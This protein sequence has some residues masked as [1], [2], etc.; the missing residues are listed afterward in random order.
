M[1]EHVIFDLGKVLVQ[2]DRQI[3]YRRLHPF[4]PDENK[5][6]L[7]HRSHELERMLHGPAVELESGRMPFDVFSG[8][9]QN[10][11][12]L[13]MPAQELWHIW[14]DIF[15]PDE[16]MIE[17][18][19]RLSNAYGAWLASNTSQVHYEWILERFPHVGFFRDAALSYELGIMKPD[20]RYFERACDKFGIEPAHALF[21]DDLKANV[22]GAEK[23]GLN[24]VVFHNRHQLLHDMHRFGLVV[25]QPTEE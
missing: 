25:P 15:T 19:T 9:V 6:L 23:A 16:A 13:S 4:V 18:G 20:P 10:L 1:I 11:L 3:A 14:C 24:A 2:F 21:I 5:P 22:L 12:G 8:R 7:T 17:L